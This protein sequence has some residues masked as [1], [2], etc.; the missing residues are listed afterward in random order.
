MLLNYIPVYKRIC[1]MHVCNFMHQHTSHISIICIY[2]SLYMYV[3]I[4]IQAIRGKLQDDQQSSTWFTSSWA[5]KLFSSV[6]KSIRP[7]ATT[8]STSASTARSPTYTTKNSGQAVDMYSQVR[9]QDTDE[10]A[11]DGALHD[12]TTTLDTDTYPISPPLIHTLSTL[13]GLIFSQA[14]FAPIHSTPW[15][16]LSSFV[17]STHI[18]INV[19]VTLL[20]TPLPSM[21]QNSWLF[22]TNTTTFSSASAIQSSTST[23]KQPAAASSTSFF[24]YLSK[25]FTPSI[26]TT[27]EQKGRNSDPPYTDLIAP[28]PSS[29]SSS[30]SSLHP[31]AHTVMCD[32][33][34]KLESYASTYDIRQL[35]LHTVYTEGYQGD[36]N[37]IYSLITIFICTLR[38]H[39]IALD[40]SELYKQ[41]V[42]FPLF[43][44]YFPPIFDLSFQCNFT[45]LTF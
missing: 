12:N 6:S 41:Q 10:H 29:F 37:S 21:E 39:L 28:N 19:W 30:S 3:Y 5:T 9:M 4:G 35:T 24:S 36:I 16:S 27:N 13:W 38:V 31:L 18:N 42:I 45:I 25:A 8:T 44:S 43:S 34:N 7:T 14:I 2:M 22:P 32:N 1:F 23:I 26:T 17:F 33:Q 40:D 11:D 20:T 15:K